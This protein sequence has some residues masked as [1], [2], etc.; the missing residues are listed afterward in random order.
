M[1]SS[2]GNIFRVAGLLCGEFTGHRWIP[3]QRPVTGSFD[4]FFISAW[5]N[6]WVNNDDVGDLR[7][8]RA[9]YDAIVMDNMHHA[10]YTAAVWFVGFSWRYWMIICILNMD[11]IRYY[12]KDPALLYR[13][14]TREIRWTRC[15]ITAVHKQNIHK[16]RLI[17]P[18]MIIHM[19]I[20]G[21][22]KT[23]TYG[24]I[25]IYV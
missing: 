19:H 21:W 1:T 24:Y 8:H 6:D 25:C 14:L 13:I 22:Y 11:I 15:R 7:R 16:H 17:Q 2:N 9:H 23:Y 12:V 3:S 20:N 5:M 18:Y 10:W 4:V